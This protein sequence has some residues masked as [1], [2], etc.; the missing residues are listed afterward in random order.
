MR[1]SF[2]RLAEHVRGILAH[3]PLS[4]HLFVFRNRSGERVK[5][6][7]WDQG[8][9]AIYYKR[10]GLTEGDR[11]I[12]VKGRVPF[13]YLCAAGLTAWRNWPARSPV[14]IRYQTPA[15][16]AAWASSGRGVASSVG[17]SRGRMIS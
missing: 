5:I 11:T 1:R 15:H 3:D 17:H 12:N 10:L 7:W 16:P 4:G 6:L 13:S 14:R 2:D 9:Y 8:G